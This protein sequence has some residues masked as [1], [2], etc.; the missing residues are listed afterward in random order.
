MRTNVTK[1]R[2]LGE[3]VNRPAH[4]KHRAG[5]GVTGAYDTDLETLGQRHTGVIAVSTDGH[6]VW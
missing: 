6:T 3:Y 2:R 4:R 5:A 1:E